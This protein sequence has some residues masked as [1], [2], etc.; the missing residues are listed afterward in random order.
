MKLFTK[1]IWK[2]TIMNWF[3]LNRGINFSFTKFRPISFRKRYD[4]GAK[5]DI[6]YEVENGRKVNAQIAEN[7]DGT[8]KVEGGNEKS[9]TFTGLEKWKGF[10]MVDDQVK[11]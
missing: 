8:M 10:R 9:K 4:K 2:V 3:K 7:D 5:W 11:T 1:A 6:V